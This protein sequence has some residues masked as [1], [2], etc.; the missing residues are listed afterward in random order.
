MI[1]TAT[2]TASSL[3]AASERSTHRCEARLEDPEFSLM[4][5]A[6][7]E[8][9][10]LPGDY[11]RVSQQPP[12]PSLVALFSYLVFHATGK[13]TEEQNQR[14]TAFDWHHVRATTSDRGFKLRYSR[15]TF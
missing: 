11:A 8:P 15:P 2:S 5:R 7:M 3:E 10:H 4:L 6:G 13:A 12:E 9:W 1:A 14:K